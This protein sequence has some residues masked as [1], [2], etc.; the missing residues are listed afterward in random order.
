MFILT[1]VYNIIYQN[2][3]LF[4][5]HLLHPKEIYKSA[6]TLLFA[7]KGKHVVFAFDIAK[8]S[9]P[10]NIEAQRLEAF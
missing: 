5:L 9:I 7:L 4:F 6:A 8:I 10:F 1:V 3:I 2:H